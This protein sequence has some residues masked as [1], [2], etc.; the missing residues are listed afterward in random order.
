MKG[1][2]TQMGYCR[3]VKVY[4]SIQILGTQ[5]VIFG[6]KSDQL[7]PLETFKSDILICL[8]GWV[9]MVRE[10]RSRLTLRFNDGSKV[11][12]GDDLA[13]ELEDVKDKRDAECEFKR[14]DFYPGQ[15]LFGAVKN[16]EA[17]QWSDC[18]QEV[19]VARKHKPYKG[20]KMT[21]EEINFVSLGVNWMC[22]AYFSS[23]SS[24]EE[25]RPQPGFRVDSDKLD[26]VKMLNVFEPCTLQIGDRNF[27]TLKENDIMMLKSDWKKLLK[28]QLLKGS[29]KKDKTPKLAVPEDVEDDGNSTDYEDM[30]DD[31]DAASVSSQDSNQQNIDE[32]SEKRK[33][34]HHPGLMTKVLKKKKLKKSKKS[35]EATSI[36]SFNSGEKVVT[37]TL[38]TRSEVEVVWQDGTVEAG[39]SS[40]ELFPV[41]HLDDH[42]FVSFLYSKNL[43]FTVWFQFPGDFVTEAKDGFQPHSYGVVQDVDHSAR[44]CKVR[45]VNESSRNFTIFG[46][47]LPDK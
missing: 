7:V 19:V 1:R 37:E 36:A 32:K 46:E 23:T 14:Y 41:Q 3:D 17:G 10:V 25:A 34:K 43:R 13:E 27:Y 5:Q 38:S 20:Y 16:V 4:S 18:S 8:D 40:S 6:A 39:I 26:Q 31:S 21:V 12:V 30:E 9:G 2:K 42:E 33:K 35:S 11:I 24:T 28:D 29:K 22:R 15:V 44:C 45:A 47:S